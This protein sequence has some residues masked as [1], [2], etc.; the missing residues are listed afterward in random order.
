MTWNGSALL[1][2][3]APAGAKGVVVVP[4]KRITY[5]GSKV[6]NVGPLSRHLQEDIG[7]VQ[8]DVPE[9]PRVATGGWWR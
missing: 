1:G 6:L 9:I 4:G 5:C 2:R 8:V 7:V 3:H